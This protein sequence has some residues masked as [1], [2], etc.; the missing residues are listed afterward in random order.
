MSME[1]DTNLIELN[2][3]PAFQQ[4]EVTVLKNKKVTNPIAKSF[5]KFFQN[6]KDKLTIK[7]I[8]R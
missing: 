6:K 7:D 3:H 1:K 2:T 8:F 5:A 4:A